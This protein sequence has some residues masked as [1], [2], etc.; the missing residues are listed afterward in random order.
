MNSNTDITTTNT[1][2]PMDSITLANPLYFIESLAGS[3][4]GRIF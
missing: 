2:A 1:G 3:I 4:F